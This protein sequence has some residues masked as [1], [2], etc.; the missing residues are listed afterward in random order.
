M[1][2]WL[3]EIERIKKDPDEMLDKKCIGLNSVSII[4]LDTN[5]EYNLTGN[6]FESGNYFQNKQSIFDP[7]WSGAYIIPGEITTLRDIHIHAIT[8][9]MISHLLEDQ[10][11]YH[12]LPQDKE[13]LLHNLIPNYPF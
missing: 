11:R 13:R 3:N 7:C 10:L 9:D 1:E 4:F 8:C 12:G 2:K 6:Q 5:K